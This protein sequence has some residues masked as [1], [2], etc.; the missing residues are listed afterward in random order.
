MQCTVLCI[1]RKVVK[2]IYPRVKLDIFSTKSVDRRSIQST[3]RWLPGPRKITDVKENDYAIVL[4]HHSA[5]K[6]WCEDQAGLLMD[7]Y[8]VC[9]DCSVATG[10]VKAKYCVMWR[11]QG[12]KDWKSVVDLL[13]PLVCSR[14]KI[15]KVQ[16]CTFCVTLGFPCNTVGRL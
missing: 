4:W 15:S 14:I 6:G 11:A 1:R 12:C 2:S 16:G 8:L 13:V 5:I 9:V 7:K 10:D 3:E